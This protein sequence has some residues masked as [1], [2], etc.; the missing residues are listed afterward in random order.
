MRIA[1]QGGDPGRIDVA[2]DPAGEGWQVTIRDNGTG[3]DPASTPSGLGLASMKARARQLG[4]T[5]A[6]TTGPGE[7]TI[8]ILSVPV[9]S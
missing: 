2:I 1:A 7:G 3:F 8:V 4:G 5:V 6:L 9:P